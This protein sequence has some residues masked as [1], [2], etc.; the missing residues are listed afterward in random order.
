[1]CF[2]IAKRSLFSHLMKTGSV[3]PGISDSSEERFAFS[4]LPCL[5]SDRLSTWKRTTSRQNIRW[6][7]NK[8]QLQQNHEFLSQWKQKVPVNAPAEKEEQEV[9]LTVKSAILDDGQRASSWIEFNR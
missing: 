6:L 5:P 3:V 4:I 1:M 2:T 7:E 9:L 8:L